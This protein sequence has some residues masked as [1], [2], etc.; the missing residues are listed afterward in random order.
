MD[1]PKKMTMF[2]FMLDIVYLL[3]GQEHFIFGRVSLVEKNVKQG[4]KSEPVQCG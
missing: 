1:P 4:S 2:Y 3:P